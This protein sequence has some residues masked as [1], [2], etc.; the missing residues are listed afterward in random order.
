[1]KKKQKNKLTNIAV[2]ILLLVGVVLVWQWYSNGESPFTKAS[3][4]ESVFGF[5]V[6]GGE[7][8]GDGVGGEY[9]KFKRCS[10]F[11]DGG[12][13]KLIPKSSGGCG[14]DID[15]CGVIGQSGRT[16]FCYCR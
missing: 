5:P 16:G 14:N 10:S 7:V 11:K 1:M 8:G 6:L 12:C 15:D 13:E 2:V 3:E 9:A 4:P